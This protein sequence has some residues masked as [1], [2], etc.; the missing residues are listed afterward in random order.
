MSD[1]RKMQKIDWY[2]H[3][4]IEQVLE[5]LSFPKISYSIEIPKNDAHGDL[6]INLAMILAR[7]L[8]KKPR[9][10]AQEIVN[11]LETDPKIFSQIE[12]AGPGFIN[13]F[14]AP[15]YLQNTVTSILEEGSRFGK[16]DFGKDQKA[17]VE[18]VSANPTGPLTI[19]HGRQAVLGDTIANLL[20]WSGFE[21]I[22][23][24][25]FNNAGRQMRVLGD[26]VRLRYHELCNQ[27]VTFPEEYY[28]GQYIIEIAQTIK[29]IHGDALL[30]L[31]EEELTIFVETA[32]NQIFEDIKK[33]LGQLGIQFDVY[34]NEKDLYDNGAIDKVVELLKDK[35]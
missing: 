25:Y 30:H 16:M 8:Q 2:L 1:W 10:I 28:Q 15:P 5:A 14:Y 19:G 18:F 12:I 9:E 13:F 26:S 4:K 22:R 24:Y 35:K 17:Q 33:T 31:S 6:S 29:E 34:F 21:V 27:P 32:E 23:E 7:Q 11:Q 20:E 3:Q